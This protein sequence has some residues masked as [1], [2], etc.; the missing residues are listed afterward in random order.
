MCL[1][2]GSTGSSKVLFM[3]KCVPGGNTSSDK[4]HTEE[5]WSDVETLDAYAKSK[6]LA[7]KAAWDFIKELPG[8]YFLPVSFVSVSHSLLLVVL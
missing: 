6:T 2:S 3:S 5:D 8:M 1:G 7:E 4:V